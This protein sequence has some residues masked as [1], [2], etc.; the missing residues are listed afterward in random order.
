MN[1]DNIRVYIS[2]LD[3]MPEHHRVRAINEWCDEMN[4][5]AMLALGLPSVPRQLA[6]SPSDYERLKAYYASVRWRG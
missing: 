6:V 1:F 2:P 3:A 4:N 5:T